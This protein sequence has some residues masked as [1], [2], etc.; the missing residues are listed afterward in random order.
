LGQLNIALH[1]VAVRL[2]HDPL[3]PHFPRSH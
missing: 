1:P 2:H 3:E